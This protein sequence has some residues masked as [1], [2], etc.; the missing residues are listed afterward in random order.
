MLTEV[1]KEREAQVELKQLRKLASAGRDKEWL[2]KSRYQYDA[3]IQEDQQNA[4]ERIR[5]AQENA[6]FQAAQ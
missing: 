3:S 1:L 4:A 5:K 6:A 2:E